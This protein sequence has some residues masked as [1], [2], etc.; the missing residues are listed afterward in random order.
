MTDGR[1]PA[2]TPHLAVV[3][4]IVLALAGC[5]QSGQPASPQVPYPTIGAT[6]TYTG[7]GWVSSMEPGSHLLAGPEPPIDV[8]LDG[9]ASL[10]VAVEPVEQR[11][12]LY[13]ATHRVVPF[14][15]T[16]DDGNRTWGVHTGYVNASTGDLVSQ[17]EIRTD[18]QGNQT[19]AP[20]LNRRGAA[21]L[22]GS[23]LFWGLEL[24]E[25]KTFTREVAPIA[26]AKGALRDR[27]TLEFEVGDRETVAG[28]DAYRIELVNPTDLRNPPNRGFWQKAVF[29]VSP[30]TP[31]IVKRV[32]SYAVPH[33]DVSPWNG[34]LTLS[35]ETVGTDR[36]VVDRSS[37]DYAWESQAV[38][39]SPWDGFRPPSNGSTFAAFPMARALSVLEQRNAQ[40][41]AFLAEHPDAMI[42]KTIHAAPGGPQRW[43]FHL[44]APDNESGL[45]AA[46]ERNPDQTPPLEY[47][48]KAERENATG[49]WVG[50]GAYDRFVS[51]D[52]CWHLWEQFTGGVSVAAIVIQM[53]A[54][55]GLFG[56][57]RPYGRCDLMVG[58]GH[59]VWAGVPYAIRYDG[60]IMPPGIPDLPT[61]PKR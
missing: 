13:Q 6:A 49:P 22:L 25:G 2:A 8:K 50:P 56:V 38:E 21:T 57:P 18:G 39:L 41:N 40:Y 59:L 60:A 36:V 47:Q 20:W 55:P 19:V 46:A 58:E 14:N 61:W 52:A 1:T 45:F 29:W 24:E 16:Y 23:S 32:A 28:Y 15:W 37:R 54:P 12:D 5:L 17:Y 42:T 10:S 9:D 48:T 7:E 4:L 51:V 26:R 11:W 27:V 3:V 30:E 33:L 31:F 34:T 53:D 43:E 35:D 44:V